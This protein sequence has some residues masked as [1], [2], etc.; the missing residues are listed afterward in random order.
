MVLIVA[1]GAT[2]AWDAGAHG[3]LVLPIAPEQVTA[4][5]V[6]VRAGSLDDQTPNLIEDRGEMP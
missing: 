4:I 5:I 2:A 6:R 1:A 3:S